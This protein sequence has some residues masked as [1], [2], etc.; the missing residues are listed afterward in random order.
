MGSRLESVLL[1]FDCTGFVSEKDDEM[2]SGGS[3]RDSVALVTL[4]RL[5]LG[6]LGMGTPGRKTAELRAVLAMG[7]GVV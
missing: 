7:G 6:W 5:E 3:L 4:D 2:V 1:L